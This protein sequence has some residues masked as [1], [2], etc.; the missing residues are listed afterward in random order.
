M[1]FIIVDI[2]LNIINDVKRKSGYSYCLLFN[3]YDNIYEI[4]YELSSSKYSFLSKHW[5]L[6]RTAYHSKNYFWKLCGCTYYMH[7]WTTLSIS[8]SYCYSTLIS[9]PQQ[10]PILMIPFFVSFYPESLLLVTHP[11]SINIDIY[12]QTLYW[13]SHPSTSHCITEFSLHALNLALP[14]LL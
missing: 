14:L 13:S 11:S 4:L 12:A 8:Y 10:L 1:Q 2:Y 9:I 3:I 5:S 6:K 7:N